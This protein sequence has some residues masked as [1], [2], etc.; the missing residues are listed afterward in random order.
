M[1]DAPVIMEIV[2]MGIGGGAAAVSPQLYRT[3]SDV[4]AAAEWIVVAN[5]NMLLRLDLTT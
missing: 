2:A 3:H 4:E 5:M 1:E